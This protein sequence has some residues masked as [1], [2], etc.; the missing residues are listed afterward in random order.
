[1][2]E[3]LS[4]LDA[5]LRVETRAEILK[6]QDRLGT[7][8]IYVTHDQV[9]AMTMGDRIAVM[10]AGVLQQVGT[11][12]ELYENPRNMFVAGFIGSPSMNLVPA[13]VV[14]GGGS[15]RIIGFRPEHVRPGQRGDGL[16]FDARVE[17]VEFLGDERLVHLSR[18]DTPLLA[19]LPVED[20][21]E[22]GSSSTFTVARER[23]YNFDAESEERV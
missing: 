15:G 9:E 14:D 23:I 22:M 4:N 7:T 5:K 11:P 17:V 13:P 21:V 20:K 18:N 12:E 16:T 8:T 19:K 1:M 2:D 6:L 3:P 10:R